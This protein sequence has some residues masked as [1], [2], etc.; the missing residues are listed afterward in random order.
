MQS[1]KGLVESSS[2]ID[3]V[4][5]CHEQI[6]N[7]SGFSDPF[8]LE[9]PVDYEEKISPAISGVIVLQNKI[10][11]RS[12]APFAGQM[13]LKSFGIEIVYWTMVRKFLRCSHQSLDK[14]TILPRIR[15]KLG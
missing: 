3:A 11:F 7:A 5:Q 9:L 12:W 1:I 10:L 2:E 8:P 13:G 6:P 15:F 4:H 14:F